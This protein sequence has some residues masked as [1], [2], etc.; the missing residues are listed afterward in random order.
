MQ[1]VGNSKTIFFSYFILEIPNFSYMRIFRKCSMFC[2]I[3]PELIYEFIAFSS[4]YSITDINSRVLI[5]KVTLKLSFASF[6]QYR[7]YLQ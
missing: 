1:I 7:T 2:R 3:I 4:C 6:F 5:S